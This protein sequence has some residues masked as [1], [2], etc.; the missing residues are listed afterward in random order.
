MLVRNPAVVKFFR[1]M[2]LLLVKQFE[3]SGFGVAGKPCR[4]GMWVDMLVYVA[5]ETSIPQSDLDNAI[6]T[7]QETLMPPHKGGIV[8][9]IDD[10]SQV[11]CVGGQNCLVASRA[12]Q[13]AVAYVWVLDREVPI[14]RQLQEFL[15]YYERKTKEERKGAQGSR[16]IPSLIREDSA[17]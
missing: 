15:T 7:V 3:R 11:F 6:T 2:E 13:G 16:G 1:K 9:F 17:G 5:K 10:D 8:G 14:H 12:L 4:I